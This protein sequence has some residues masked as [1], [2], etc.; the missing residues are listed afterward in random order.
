MRKID[1]SFRRGARQKFPLLGSYRTIPSELGEARRVVQRHFQTWE[2][3]WE[4]AGAVMIAVRLQ[5]IKSALYCPSGETERPR[6]C[7]S[8][9]IHWKGFSN[10]PI[11]TNFNAVYYP[12]HPCGGPIQIPIATAICWQHSSQ[13]G[14]FF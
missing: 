13:L 3:E 8:L 6:P 7:K 4:G 12:P 1:E 5:S 2:T 14:S 11:R 9:R 10:P